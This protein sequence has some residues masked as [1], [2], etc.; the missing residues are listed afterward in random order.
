M[1]LRRRKK[2][3][4][5]ANT[6]EKLRKIQVKLYVLLIWMVSPHLGSKKG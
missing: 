5:R 4:E 1:E 3:D 2:E 6:E